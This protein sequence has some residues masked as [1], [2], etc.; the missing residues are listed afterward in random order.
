MYAQASIR[1]ECLLDSVS[2]C[3]SIRALP[4]GKLFALLLCSLRS[5]ALPPEADWRQPLDVAAILAVSQV[6]Y[7][8]A[9]SDSAEAGEQHKLSIMQIFC[10]CLFLSSSKGGKGTGEGLCKESSA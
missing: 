5:R 10:N 9:S 7:S 8:T 6:D 4:A 2:L 1:S 3:R